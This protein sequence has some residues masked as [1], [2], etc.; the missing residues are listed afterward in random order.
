MSRGAMK[1]LCLKQSRRRREENKE[2][3]LHGLTYPLY[4]HVAEENTKTGG[5][6]TEGQRTPWNRTRQHGGWR[7]D[8]AD[9]WLRENGWVDGDDGTWWRVGDA[10]VP[11]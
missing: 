7:R 3:H 1:S 5:S 10:N 6:H 8:A 4:L 11:G 9:T 2:T